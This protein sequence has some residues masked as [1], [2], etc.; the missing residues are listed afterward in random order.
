[1]LYASV[2]NRVLSC[3]KSIKS[4]TARTV[5]C[6]KRLVPKNFGMLV[7]CLYLETGARNID[8][9]QYKLAFKVYRHG[10]E[11]VFLNSVSAFPALFLF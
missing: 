11:V 8:I 10:K 9:L 7:N 2:L 5:L 4:E 6:V 3:L 1:M